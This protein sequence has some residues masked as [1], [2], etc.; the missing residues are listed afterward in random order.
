M[1]IGM[2]LISE[3]SNS[4][5]SMTYGKNLLQ[6]LAKQHPEDVYSVFIN[7]ESR[8]CFNVKCENVKYI[9]ARY[10]YNKNPFVRRIAQQIWLPYRAKQCKL[11]VLHSINNVIPFGYSGR[12]IVTILDMTA[13]VQPK[14]FGYIKK[15]FLKSLVP[16]S[17]R[18]ADVVITIS[19]YVKKQIIEICS[20]HPSKV[21]TAYCGAD[22]KKHQLV[23]SAPQ[24]TLPPKYLLFI[25]T[26]EPGKNIVR[27]IQ[28]YQQVLRGGPE[29]LKLVIAGRK[30]WLYG[31]IFSEVER[32]NLRDKVLF[33]GKITNDGIIHVLKHAAIFVFPSLD[34]GFGL[35]VLE[36]MSAGCPVVTSN[37]SA[38]PEITGTAAVLVNPHD[39]NSIANGV[40]KILDEQDLAK[41]LI[42][43]GKTQA[44]KFTWDRTADII[45]QQYC[46][47]V[48]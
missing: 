23:P 9:E 27:L 34:E 7:E 30:G 31:D 1:H 25:G 28:A 2:D 45:H 42:Q 46:K 37:I 44:D 48:K 20:V 41:E 4:A 43:K 14:R 47:I 33:L 3:S 13:F 5:G 11:D 12:K 39:V 40:R 21:V 26:L 18:E 15:I 19:N 10:P 22:D 24:F 16:W 6:E 38:L 35:P 32:L 17:A 36:A 8:S 29:D